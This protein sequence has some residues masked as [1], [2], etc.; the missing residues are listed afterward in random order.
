MPRVQCTSYIWFI[1]LS[2]CLIKTGHTTHFRLI[3]GAR[4]VPAKRA[5]AHLCACT[6]QLARVIWPVPCRGLDFRWTPDRG[7]ALQIIHP[8]LCFNYG[9]FSEPTFGWMLVGWLEE[10]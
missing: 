5:R 2:L 4:V 7:A 8:E 3:S 6:P 10:L 1:D 9:C